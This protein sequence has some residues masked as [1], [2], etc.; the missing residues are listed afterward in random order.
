MSVGAGLPEK[1]PLQATR[2]GGK[3]R[4]V[5]NI[6]TRRSGKN[7]AHVHCSSN[8][9]KQGGS[10]KSREKAFTNTTETETNCKKLHQTDSCH[11]TWRH[12]RFFSCLKQTDK[13]AGC[14]Q[15]KGVN[16]EHHFLSMYNNE[17]IVAS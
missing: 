16:V 11:L 2:K 6:C 15:N 13:K 7:T 1:P 17:R 5:H 4:V 14:F 8:T 9:S 3:W 12:V 10:A